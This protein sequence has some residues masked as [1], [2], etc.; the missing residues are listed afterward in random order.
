MTIGFVL[1]VVRAWWEL[2]AF[3]LINAVSGF[4]GIYSRLAR[5]RI[6]SIEVP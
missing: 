2:V 5:Q 1:L 6:K 3:D 4:Q